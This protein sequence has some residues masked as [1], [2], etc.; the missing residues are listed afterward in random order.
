MVKTRELFLGWALVVL[1]L[2]FVGCTQ[3]EAEQEKAPEP[4]IEAPATEIPAATEEMPMVP[5]EGEEEAEAETPEG[6]EG[7]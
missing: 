2:T 7:Q 6:E 3:K 1:S 5:T 4:T